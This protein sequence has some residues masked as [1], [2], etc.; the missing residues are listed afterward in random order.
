MI[1][2]F[3]PIWVTRRCGDSDHRRRLSI[4]W[5]HACRMGVWVCYVVVVVAGKQQRTVEMNSNT[6]ES[7]N[8]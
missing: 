1:T 5:M 7:C 8:Q 6:D 4:S 3:P 2:T